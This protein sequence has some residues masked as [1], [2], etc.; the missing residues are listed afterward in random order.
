MMTFTTIVVTPE[1]PTAPVV[2]AAPTTIPPIPNNTPQPM[3][4]TTT[5]NQVLPMTPEYPVHQMTPEYLAYNKDE[6][7]PG[8]K[9]SPAD[10]STKDPLF[11]SEQSNNPETPPL[12]EYPYFPVETKMDN[13]Q[14]P[15]EDGVDNVYKYNNYVKREVNSEDM[16]SGL[17]VI[18]NN[19]NV[20]FFPCI[21]IS[22]RSRC[23]RF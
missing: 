8:Y 7:N 20:Y 19:L 3:T 11:V 18:L 2:T 1:V 10:Q 23:N 13:P 9:R 6:E 22:P 4:T 5:E 16:K 21:I 15:V 17:I 14:P 12:Q